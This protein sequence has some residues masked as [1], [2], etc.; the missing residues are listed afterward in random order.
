VAVSANLSA[1][2]NVENL[3]VNSIAFKT[4][5][6][7]IALVNPPGVYLASKVSGDVSLLC[8]HFISSLF[9]ATTELSVTSLL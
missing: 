6:S 8:I 1:S 7:L 4:S 5:A 3:S 9:Q 2:S